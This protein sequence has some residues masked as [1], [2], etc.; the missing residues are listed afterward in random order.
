MTIFDLTYEMDHESLLN[1]FL[2]P[3]PVIEPLQTDINSSNQITFCLHLRRGGI[4]KVDA[5]A[6]EL[7][8]FVGYF[9]K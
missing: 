3:K 5:N 1:I 9:S 8:K 6:Y 7:V 2:N 4:E